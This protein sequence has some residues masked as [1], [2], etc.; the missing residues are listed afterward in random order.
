MCPRYTIRVPCS[1]RHL[2]PVRHGQRALADSWVGT[3]EDDHDQAAAQG[4]AHCGLPGRRP[5]L[6]APTL[7]KAVS[8]LPNTGAQGLDGTV[9]GKGLVVI[10]VA[11]LLL[12]GGMWLT[13]GPSSE[14]T[15]DR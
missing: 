10:V 3:K 7:T 8:S 11:T 14:G 9:D 6:P 1:Q 2:G 15:S 12:I 5:P 13:V 4:V